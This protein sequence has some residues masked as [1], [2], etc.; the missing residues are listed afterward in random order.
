VLYYAVAVQSVLTPLGYLMS[1]EQIGQSQQQV[2]RTTSGTMLYSGVA[3][4]AFVAFVLWPSLVNAPYGWANV[5]LAQVQPVEEDRVRS[6]LPASNEPRSFTCKEPLPE[7]TLG[8]D[9]NPSA[10]LCQHE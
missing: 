1:K 3:M 5:V 2:Q 9:S 6:S 10:P 8:R 7:F 4:L